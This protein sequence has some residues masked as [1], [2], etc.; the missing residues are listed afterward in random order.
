MLLR[1]RDAENLIESQT[2][3]LTE[4]NNAKRQCIIGILGSI[5]TVLCCVTPV[6]AFLLVGIGLAA[7]IPYLDFLLVPLFCL[8]LAI[9]SYGWLQH[10]RIKK[11]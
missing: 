8:F 9:G 5:T 3:P 4:Q 7:F 1:Q 11:G 10:K 6:F 2:M